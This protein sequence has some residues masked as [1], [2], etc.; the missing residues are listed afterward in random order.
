MR[1]PTAIRLEVL[2]DDSLASRGPGRAPNGSWVLT[3]FKM[4][5]EGKPVELVPV[6]ADF[7]QPGWPLANALDGKDDTGWG[8]WP[9]VG[10]PHEAV[11]EIKTKFRVRSSADA[12]Q[13]TLMSFRLQFRSPYKQ[14]TIGKF[15]LSIT[16][17][18]TVLLR[19]IPDD[20]KAA[21]A[22]D[23]ARRNDAQKK[24]ISEF[25]LA[26]EPRLIAAK[27][28]ADDAK[29]AREK[30]E[31]ETPRTMVAC[32]TARSRAMHLHP[33]QGSA[34][35]KFADL[36]VDHGTPGGSRLHSPRMRRRIASPSRAGSSHPSI[37]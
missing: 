19:P 14:H 8:A 15:R 35:D 28:T 32:A 36:K 26:S 22:I 24:A 11:F 20:V 6:R 29:A 5:G 34:Y 37:H 21:I 27:K 1:G 9:Q 7:E 18:P 16:N 3:E 23:A 12:R 30:A 25:Y 31:R 4:L 2:P 17:S 13:D 33:R 10:K